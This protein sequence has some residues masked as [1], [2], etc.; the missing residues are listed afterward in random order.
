M[1]IDFDLDQLRQNAIE[2]GY[3]RVMSIVIALHKYLDTDGTIVP[4][5]K[6]Y[7]TK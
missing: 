1:G 7:N 6:F 4:N 5:K 3:T 2:A